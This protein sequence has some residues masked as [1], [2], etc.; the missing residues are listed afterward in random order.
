MGR[1]KIFSATGQMDF[2]AADTLLR[3]IWDALI[4]VA[5][6]EHIKVR[7]VAEMRT[8]MTSL[9]WSATTTKVI[10]RWIPP[11]GIHVNR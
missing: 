8:Q 10:K 4:I 3:H 9:D 2:Y 1:T 5:V 11:T 6:I 7:L